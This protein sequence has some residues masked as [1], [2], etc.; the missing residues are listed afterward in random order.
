MDL[1]S[2]CVAIVAMWH[3]SGSG[4]GAPRPTFSYARNHVHTQVHNA[5]GYCYINMERVGERV[6]H[7]HTTWPVWRA[8]SD[9]VDEHARSVVP[10]DALC[11]YSASCTLRQ[12]E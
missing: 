7:V 3:S 10:R 6:A 11:F 8:S 2:K 5:L 1:A 9:A 12:V 4:S